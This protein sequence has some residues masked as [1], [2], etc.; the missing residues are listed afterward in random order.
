MIMVM[1]ILTAYIVDSQI[2]IDGLIT[3]NQNAKCL[4]RIY[5]GSG[6][7]GV[8]DRHFAF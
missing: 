7:E 3:L 5:R 8:L 1:G 6:A 2:F 4:S